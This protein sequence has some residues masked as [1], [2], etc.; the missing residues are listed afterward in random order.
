MKHLF[1]HNYHQDPHL[2]DKLRTEKEISGIFNWCLEGLKSIREHTLI[3]PNVIHQANEKYRKSSDKIGL[4]MENC[5]T[6]ANTNT[7]VK[8]AY[9]EYQKWCINNGYS[10]E[11][12]VSFVDYLRKRNL[13]VNIATI[14]GKT[15]KHVL[16]GY[17][18]I[19]IPL[20]EEFEIEGI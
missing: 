3:I 1:L 14:N 11:G 13:I 19:S 17:S 2:K 12:K 18:L 20:I 8:D 15:E 5:L 4:F 9:D 6:K 16:K 10:C 7:K